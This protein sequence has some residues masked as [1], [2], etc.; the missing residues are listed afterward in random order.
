MLALS[1]E[2]QQ[3]VEM[4]LD[5]I[6]HSLEVDYGWLQLVGSED[7]KLRLV[8]SLGTTTEMTAVAG[9]TNSQRALGERVIVGLRMV[10][11]DLSRQSKDGLSAFGAA[12][13]HSLVIVPIRTY[14]TQGVIGVASRVRKHLDN[15]TAELLMTI[16][17]LVGATLNVAELGRLALDRERLRVAEGMS[18]VEQDAAKIASESAKAT[19]LESPVTEEIVPLAPP[20]TEVKKAK[21]KE[22]RS[23]G[24]GAF[25]DHSRSMSSF[26]RAHQEE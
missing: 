3:I 17:G 25:S 15:E 18:G 10:V 19:P 23:G 4:V 1:N 21:S 26:R 5:K 11:P 22:N 12:G 14:H 9:L 13:F 24:N 8:A 2:P 6:L 20:D 7:R 16:A